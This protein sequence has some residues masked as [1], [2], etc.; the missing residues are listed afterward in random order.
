M[1]LKAGYSRQTISANIAEMIRSGHPQNQA[2]AASLDNAV[3]SF[4]KKFSRKV[5]PEYLK[6]TAWMMAHAKKHG[7]KTVKKKR[8]PAKRVVKKK[9]VKRNP[10]VRIRGPVDHLIKLMN[11]SVDPIKVGYFDGIGFDTSPRVASRFHSKAQAE[12]IAKTLKREL[13]LR[14]PKWSIGVIKETEL[15]GYNRGQR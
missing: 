5:F 6:K 12:K 7:G 8:N 13:E 14:A 2:V 9:A 10:G 15:P 11:L 3:K 4:R 1:P